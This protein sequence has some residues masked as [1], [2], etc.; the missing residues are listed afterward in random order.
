MASL[1]SPENVDSSNTEVQAKLY[2]EPVGNANDILEFYRV[3]TVKIFLLHKFIH[4][5]NASKF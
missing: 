2:S 5:L 1:Y 4:R 3:I